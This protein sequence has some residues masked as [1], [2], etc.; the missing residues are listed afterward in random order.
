MITNYLAAGNTKLHKSI[1]IWSLPAGK[2]CPG[3]TKYC[4]KFCYARKCERCFPPA[5]V[6][7]IENL[8]FSKT[9]DFVKG[10]IK[11][12]FDRKFTRVRFHERGDAYNQ[13]YLDKLFAI[14]NELPEVKF[15]MY[16]KSFDLDFTNKPKNLNLYF[17][18]DPSSD[19]VRATKGALFTYILPKGEKPKEGWVTCVDN[20]GKGY[21]GSTCIHCWK[22]N[23]EPK[24]YFAQH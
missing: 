20:G 12:I 8:A 18:L 19:K 15:L 2:T 13:E 11:E 1:G 22:N 6:K 17:S 4:I 3:A 24:V 14:C 5:K 9:K 10:L 23:P 16:T 21:C 7:G